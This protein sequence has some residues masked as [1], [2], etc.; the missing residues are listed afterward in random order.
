MRVT[1]I[2]GGTPYVLGVV[3]G[4]EMELIKEG[5]VAPHYDSETGRHAVGTR[6]AT[7]RVRR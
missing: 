4:F 6:H 5:G 1:I 7:F 2:Q 3:E